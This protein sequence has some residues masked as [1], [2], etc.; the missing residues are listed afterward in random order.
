[1]EGTKEIEK[2][3]N[4]RDLIFKANRHVYNFQ[5]FKTIRSFDNSNIGGRI[6]LRSADEDQSNLLVE[7]IILRKVQKPKDLNKKKQNKRTNL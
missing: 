6:T 7:I 4:K 2:M 1:M 3:A 5:Q